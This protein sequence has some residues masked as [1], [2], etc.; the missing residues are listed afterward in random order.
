MKRKKKVRMG[1]VHKMG[2]HYVYCESQR[3]NQTEGRKKKKTK[4][5]FHSISV[6]IIIRLRLTLLIAK[7]SQNSS[8]KSKL[9]QRVLRY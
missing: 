7:R 5:M 9:V 3:R 2:K 1:D 8:G 6:I 4:C